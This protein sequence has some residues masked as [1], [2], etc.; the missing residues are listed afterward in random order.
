MEEARK[1]YADLFA[2]ELNTKQEE[3]KSKQASRT[4]STALVASRRYQYNIL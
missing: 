1:A 4:G 3:V 2:S